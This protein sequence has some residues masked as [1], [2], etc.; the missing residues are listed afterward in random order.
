M[1]RGLGRRLATNAALALLLLLAEGRQLQLALRTQRAPVSAV[2]QPPSLLFAGMVLGLTVAALGLG[3]G[4]ALQG[5]EPSSRVFRLLPIL[6]AVTVF[7]EVFVRGSTH[8][9]M[10]PDRE[11]EGALGQF[12]A[13]ARTL[14]SQGQVS[15]DGLA[16]QGAADALP[17]PPYRVRGVLL[18]RYRVEVRGGCAGPAEAVAGAAA[19]TL[20]YCVA[21]D[22]KRAWVG[23]VALPAE[24]QWGLPQIFTRAGTAVFAEVR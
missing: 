11:L 13:Q 19:G 16:L 6:L 8:P 2:L 18:E 5:Y 10:T 3:L 21:P 24:E 9:L 15:R 22:S 7:V 14:G 1:S 12:A 20:V 4:A 17:R 23:A